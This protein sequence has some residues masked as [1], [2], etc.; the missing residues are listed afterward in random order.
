MSLKTNASS[1]NMYP[2]QTIGKYQFANGWIFKKKFISTRIINK[3]PAKPYILSILEI[4]LF[5]G[6]KLFEQSL[7]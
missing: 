7:N 1:V 6:Y 2:S 3:M 5:I 4:I